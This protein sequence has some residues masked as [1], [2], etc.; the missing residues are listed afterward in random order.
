MNSLI[1]RGVP[2]QQLF[3]L[4]IFS[5]IDSS[6]FTVVS[7]GKELKEVSVSK[8]YFLSCKAQSLEHDLTR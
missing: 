3:K 8:A 2:E 6:G 5:F 4:N 7:E 1:W